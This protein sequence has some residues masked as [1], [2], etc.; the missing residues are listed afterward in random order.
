[1]R[2]ATPYYKTGGPWENQT[3]IF[4]V[5]MRHTVVI[6]T[7][8][9][10]VRRSGIEPDVPEGGRVTAFCITIDTSDALFFSFHSA[11]QN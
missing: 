2:L 1:M 11:E 6:L 8:H 5:Q 4:A 9:N 3:P 7:A 10:L